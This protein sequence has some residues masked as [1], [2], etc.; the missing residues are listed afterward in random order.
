MTPVGPACA[1]HRMCRLI[2]SLRPLHVTRE[3]R[4]RNRQRLCGSGRTGEFAQGYV[5]PGPAVTSIQTRNSRSS[6]HYHVGNR[7]PFPAAAVTT[8]PCTC[9][10]RFVPRLTIP[11][12]ES[13]R[14]GLRA[15]LGATWLPTRYFISAIKNRGHSYQYRCTEEQ[16]RSRDSLKSG[17]T[18]FL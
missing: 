3:L 9:L 18:V 13:L 2:Y 7:P 11:P 4:S 8:P 1:R 6:L 10:S 17:D 14:P 12:A 16:L 15:G 5:K